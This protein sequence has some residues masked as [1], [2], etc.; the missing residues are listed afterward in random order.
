[1]AKFYGTIGYVVTVEKR[2][3]VFEATETQVYGDIT[4]NL[5]RNQSENNTTIQ[6]PML[7]QQVSF[8][9]DAFALE[10]WPHIRYVKWKGTYWNVNSIDDQYPRILLSL[11]GVYNGPK[12]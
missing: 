2:P 8:V 5:R 12:A 3:G 4:R 1:M 10:N 6:T 9:A 7:D 11:G